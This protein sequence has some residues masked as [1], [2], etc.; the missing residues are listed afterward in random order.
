MRLQLWGTG[1]PR[2]LCSL[3]KA[4]ESCSFS[5]CSAFF[6]VVCD[7]RDGVPAPSMPSQKAKIS[8]ALLWVVILSDFFFSLYF[9]PFLQCIIHIFFFIMTT[10][11]SVLRGKCLK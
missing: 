3:R 1:L 4:V 5:V 10:K 9:S 6:L 7:E 8:S 2:D 11:I